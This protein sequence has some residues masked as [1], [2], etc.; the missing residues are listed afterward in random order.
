MN[1]MR[2]GGALTVLGLGAYLGAYWLQLL[3]RRRLDARA[4]RAGG[5]LFGAGP[6]PVE[7]SGS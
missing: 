3:R 1:I 6:L 4:R 5:R 2:V 7:D